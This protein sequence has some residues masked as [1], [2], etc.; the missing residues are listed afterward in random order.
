[1]KALIPAVLLSL[2]L[3]GAGCAL[4][5]PEE[6]LYLLSAKDRATQHDVRLHLGQ[7]SLVTTT[8]SGE[9]VWIYKIRE[10]VEGDMT[11]SWWCDEYTLTF[12]VTGVLGDW[13]HS[14]QKCG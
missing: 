4:F 12:K 1:M 9:A 3:T 5:L 7:P 8:P 13:T 2:S 6:T 10:A 14:S 11:R